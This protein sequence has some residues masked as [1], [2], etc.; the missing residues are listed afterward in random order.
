[1]RN[2][3]IPIE[4]N[5]YQNNNNVGRYTS[6]EYTDNIFRSKGPLPVLSKNHKKKNDENLYLSK[7]NFPI[8]NKTLEL[9]NRGEFKVCQKYINKND[10]APSQKKNNTS[11][12]TNTVTNEFNPGIGKYTDYSNNIDID[13]HLRHGYK[14]ISMNTIVKQQINCENT[15]VDKP[16]LLDNPIC[17][18]YKKYYNDSETS[19]EKNLSSNLDR[20]IYIDNIFKDKDS[21][22]DDNLVYFN[23]TNN[24]ETC[25][26]NLP[27][28]TES[29]NITKL[30]NLKQPLLFQQSPDIA[31]PNTLPKIP[32][33]N[34]KILQ[35]EWR[36]CGINPF[37]SKNDK[38]N[39]KPKIPISKPSKALP[40]GPVRTNQHLENIW[41][42][43]TKR[44]YI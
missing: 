16:D 41:N 29:S 7:R 11:E 2:N 31:Y 8:I 37:L 42:N 36:N 33:V 21:V 30:K 24:N 34:D 10:M 6:I 18:N 28:Y 23:Y 40:I 32:D 39:I 17:Q 13:S 35:D 9:N 14:K 15:V 5:N 38:A 44:K 1:M 19:V 22:R 26:E 27:S 20:D 3:V 4:S 25:L 12:I 43:V